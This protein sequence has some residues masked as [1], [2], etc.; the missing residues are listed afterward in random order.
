MALFYDSCSQCVLHCYA[1]NT[2]V[3]NTL[4]II[5][6]QEYALKMEILVIT[7]AYIQKANPL[8]LMWKESE[9]TRY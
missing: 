5:H 9:M 7:R 2:H 1:M 4:R 6:I 3:Y 8:F